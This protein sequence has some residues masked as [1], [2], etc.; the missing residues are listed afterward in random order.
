MDM[1]SRCGLFYGALIYGIRLA[2][3]ENVL[4]VEVNG[5]SDICERLLISV[6]PAVASPERRTV[7]V[8][9][10]AAILEFVRLDCNFENVGLHSGTHSSGFLKPL[11]ACIHCRMGPSRP[12]PHSLGVLLL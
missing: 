2:R 1:N 3:F 11:K 7:G 12:R 5:L 6:P 4:N 9:S 8:P 10:I